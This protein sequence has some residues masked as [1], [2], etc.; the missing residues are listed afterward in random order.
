MRTKE[1]RDRMVAR[2]QDAFKKH[3]TFEAWPPVTAK[4]VDAATV[5]RAVVEVPVTEA[6]YL[7]ALY[8]I[9]ALGEPIGR[10][11]AILVGRRVADDAPQVSGR[12][13]KIGRG[14]GA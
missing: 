3:P 5:L 2:V 10:T 14:E 8:E 6:T 7:T 1:S 11:E 13:V 9:C 12:R 4:D